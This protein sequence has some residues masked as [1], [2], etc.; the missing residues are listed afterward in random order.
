MSGDPEFKEKTGIIWW[1]INRYKVLMPR[2][3]TSDTLE[4][5]FMSLVIFYNKRMGVSEDN[6]NDRSKEDA[7]RFI[8]DN[9]SEI[10]DAQTINK[11]ISSA[12]NNYI[13]TDRMINKKFNRTDPRTYLFSEN[14]E[15]R[16]LFQ[17]GLSGNVLPRFY[18]AVDA[19][20]LKFGARDKDD[21]SESF[22]A[23]VRLPTQSA[24]KNAYAQSIRLDRARQDAAAGI[25]SVDL[26][27]EQ[28]AEWFDQ[29]EDEPVP[30]DSD[31]DET[32]ESEES[33][34]HE[35]DIEMVNMM[36]LEGP[37]RYDVRVDV[38]WMGD[39]F[40][41][42]SPFGY[43]GDWFDKCRIKGMMVNPGF[44][45]YIEDNIERLKPNQDEIKR[46]VHSRGPELSTRL[47][48]CG[49]IYNL[50]DPLDDDNLRYTVLQLEDCLIRR[51]IFSYVYAGILLEGIMAKV[52]PPIEPDNRNN[53]KWNDLEKLLRNRVGNKVDYSKL[54]KALESWKT[55]TPSRK[56]SRPNFKTDLIF[57][58]TSQIA[59]ESPYLYE[60][61]IDELFDIYNRRN[62]VAHADFEKL[63]KPDS[64]YISL[65]ERA[66]TFLC[67][68]VR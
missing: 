25:S 30:F 50:I 7:R 1:P 52:N 47:R 64:E 20:S 9:F 6:Y 13:T 32:F 3:N 61:C 68:C 10:V 23:K 5:L 29:A 41:Y 8:Q 27:Y 56:G 28:G 37:I 2:Y 63:E 67:S 31:D 66:V 38:Q 49:N 22:S 17:D 57:L 18:S 46:I 19:E 26:D 51:N 21:T 62:R 16:Y 33:V 24:M 15:V 48:K 34:R 44:K 12:E 11:V 42:D 43:I 4:W 45:K 54:G 65:L 35:I 60:K 39:S 55:Y 53:L 36:I 14:M 59:A 58:F 40:V